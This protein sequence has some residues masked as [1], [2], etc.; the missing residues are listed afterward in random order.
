MSVPKFKKQAALVTLL[1]LSSTASVFAQQQPDA[2]RTIQEL[3]P[4]PSLP[5]PSPSV[6]LETPQRQMQEPGGPQVTLNTIILEGNTVFSDQTLLAILGDANG[7]AFDLA[8]MK[9][10]ADRVTNYYHAHDYPFARAFIPAQSMKDGTLRIEIVEGRYGEIRVTPESSRAAT[11]QKFLDSLQP[12][13]VIRGKPLERAALILDDQPGYSV[14]PVVRPGALA[15]T[16]DLDVRLTRDS[17]F[18]GNVG[19]DNHGN[20]YTGRLRAQS[21]LFANS[22]FLFGDQATLSTI[23]TEEDMWFGAAGYSVPLGYSGL[24]GNIGYTQTY[25]ELGKEFEALD[26]HGTAKIASA[27]L[28]YP[29]LRS[30]QANVTLSAQY[31]HKWLEDRQS[32]TGTSDSKSSDTL[33]LSVGFD[34]RDTFGGGGIT[35]GA[36]SWTPGTLDLDAG[37]SATDGGSAKTDGTFNKINL[38]V[39][40]VQ[41][42][43]AGF[44]V[45]GRVSGQAATDNLDSSEKFG[46]GGPNGVRA[47]PTGEGYGD[48]GALGQV[49]VR[50]TIEDMVT[51]YAFYDAGWVRTNAD[52]FAAGDNDRSI[53]GAGIGVRFEEAGFNADASLAWRTNGGDPQSDSKDETPLLFFKA[54]YSF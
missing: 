50:Y 51:P 4:A 10:L 29:L 1:L 48:E 13:S 34:V 17:R 44:T 32:S 41:A 3:R 12:D 42:L 25:Y 45:F 5:A 35:Y 37:L 14:M 18:G 52:P 49:E 21:N 23:Y 15:G 20:R 39:A 36:L 31:Q 28:S 26:A 24:R 27:G 19:I 33:P 11:A 16:G 6:S 46:L 54:G 9:A 47:Y 40:R 22:P 30:Q 43:P 2:G 7:Q 8:G 38:D 53:S